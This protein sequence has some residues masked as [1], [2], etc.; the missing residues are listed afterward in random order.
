MLAKGDAPT[1]RAA[2]E[3]L[4]NYLVKHTSR[5]NYAWRLGCRAAGELIGSGAVELQA[6]TLG[7]RLKARGASWVKTEHARHDGLG[8]RPSQRPMGDILEMHHLTR[9]VGGP[10][11]IVSGTRIDKAPIISLLCEMMK[12]SK[13]SALSTHELR[14][15]SLHGP[16]DAPVPSSPSLQ[17]ASE[18]FRAMG[19]VNR[20][21]LLE[22]LK[23]GE[24]CVTEIVAAS[25]EKFST[26]SQRLRILRAERLVTR[27]REGKHLFYALTDR[28]VADLIENAL[29]H[30]EEFS[31]SQA[32]TPRKGD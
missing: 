11:V 1:R 13:R 17:G 14:C 7:T 32:A 31:A 12:R 28:H 18:L 25:N 27:R 10:F 6:K 22:M 19:E 4:T 21:R 5:L 2:L 20:L 26:I 30:A 15:G 29:A 8:L 23:H 24:R 9:P 16:V 3:R